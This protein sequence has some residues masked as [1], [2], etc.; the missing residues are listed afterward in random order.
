MTPENKLR[1]SIACAGF[2]CFIPF[3][4][5]PRAHAKPAILSG[6]RATRGTV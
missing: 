5:S 4:G 1:S 6:S 2:V 3:F